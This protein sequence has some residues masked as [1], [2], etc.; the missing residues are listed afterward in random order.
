MT[1]QAVRL[2]AGR[3]LRSDD[4]IAGEKEVAAEILRANPDFGNPHAVRCDWCHE[5]R[6]LFR[7]ESDGPFKL[8]ERGWLCEPCNIRAASQEIKF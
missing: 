6:T 5:I 4:L 7:D 2:T 1:R 3:V 8:M